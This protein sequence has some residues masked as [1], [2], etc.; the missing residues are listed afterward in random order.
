LLNSTA[1]KGGLTRTPELVGRL[2]GNVLR[3]LMKFAMQQASV[4][5]GLHCARLLGQRNHS[6]EV[7]GPSW[8]PPH[9]GP[10]IRSSRKLVDNVPAKSS[11]LGAATT[12]RAPRART[13]G[14]VC[15]RGPLALISA[16]EL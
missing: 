1:R 5:L 10:R 13:S 6:V 3:R 4:F 15:R 14:D 9:L 16:L 12:G 2:A 11:P 8:S 7:D